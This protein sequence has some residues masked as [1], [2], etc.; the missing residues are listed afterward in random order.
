MTSHHCQHTPPASPILLILLLCAL[1]CDKPLPSPT[2]VI[3]AHDGVYDFLDHQGNTVATLDNLDDF[4]ATLA[5]PEIRGLVQDRRVV[6]RFVAEQG[7]NGSQDIP[8][9]MMPL[10]AKLASAE[11]IMKQEFEYL[12]PE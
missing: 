6:V 2:L 4:D 10:L 7:A 8:E 11:G 9:R 12:D 1:G 3:H 5:R